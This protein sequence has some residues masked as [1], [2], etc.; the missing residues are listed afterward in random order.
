MATVKFGSKSSDN[1]FDLAHLNMQSIMG[2]FTKT[3]MGFDSHG[4]YL[5]LKEN[6]QNYVELH[7]KFDF[8]HGTKS[9]SS[10]IQ[11][12][13]EITI[14]GDGKL[15][16]TATG[17]DIL[18]ADIA[19]EASFARYLKHEAYELMGN[20]GKNRFVASDLSDKFDGIGGNDFLSGLGGKDKLLGGSGNDR[21]IGGDGN[22]WMSGG[23]GSDTF[24]FKR[25]FDSDKI[26]DFDA[27]GR[28]HDT[29]DLSGYSGISK[30]SQVDIHRVSG[31]VEI[32]L[33][34]H[35]SITLLHVNI[36]DLDRFDFAF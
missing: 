32:E 13:T 20:D 31:G 17:L 15:T 36:H 12:I 23:S 28:D 27:K 29:I 14:V 11:K 2:N 34:N 18:K 25:G 5:V 16:Y 6:N 24:I 30:F 26:T 21:L 22:D 1:N 4:A 35:D 7:G 10:V 9:I 8:S 33:A 3:S 19:D